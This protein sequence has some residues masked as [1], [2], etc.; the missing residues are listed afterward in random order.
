LLRDLL[1]SSHESLFSLSFDFFALAELQW[2]NA[3]PNDGLANLF[4]DD[5]CSWRNRTKE[6]FIAN[7]S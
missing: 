6:L 7:H 1:E 3:S 2:P 5:R 4:D